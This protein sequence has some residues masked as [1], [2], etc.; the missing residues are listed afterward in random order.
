MFYP[1]FSSRSLPYKCLNLK[2]RLTKEGC[3]ESGFK[4]IIYNGKRKI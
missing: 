2:T 1:Q 3:L 4:I